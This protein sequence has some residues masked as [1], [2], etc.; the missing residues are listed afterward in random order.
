MSSKNDCVLQIQLS[1]KRSVC[2]AKFKKPSCGRS[3]EHTTLVRHSVLVN[4]EFIW[5]RKI[6]LINYLVPNIAVQPIYLTHWS[7]SISH[8]NHDP[9][10]QIT[11]TP[12]FYLMI[13]IPRQVQ[14]CF[15]PSIQQLNFH[16][17]RTYRCIIQVSTYRSATCFTIWSTNWSCSD[18]STCSSSTSGY[19]ATVDCTTINHLIS[20]LLHSLKDYNY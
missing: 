8:T 3:A 1:V 2:N 20:A 4:N 19:W 11:I 14:Y 16:T 17:R 13:I 18:R 5:Q 6:Y 7:H 12:T 9:T 15:I 10:I